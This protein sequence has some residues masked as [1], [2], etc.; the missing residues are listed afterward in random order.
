MTSALL[1]KPRMRGLLASRLKK[2]LAVAGIGAM[3]IF[4]TFKFGLMIPRRR[5]YDEFYKNYDIEKEFE[6]MRKTG[7]FQSAPLK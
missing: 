6:A 7:V 5:A 1:T 3:G 4:L 2:Y